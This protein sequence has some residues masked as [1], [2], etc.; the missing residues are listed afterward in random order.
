[1]KKIYIAIALFLLA[2]AV[3]VTVYSLVNGDFDIRNSASEDDENKYAPEIVSVP[4]TKATVGEKYNY[5]VKAIDNDLIELSAL[6]FIVNDKPDWLNW[7]DS[8]RMFSGTP[9]SSDVGTDTV[10][11]Q[12]S[13]GKWLGTQ[14]FSIE[15]S[16]SE[17]GDESLE[18]PGLEEEEKPSELSSEESL[19]SLEDYG[20]ETV[21]D[22]TTSSS[23]EL[24][25]GEAVLG[26]TDAELPN[27]A[28]MGVVV[29]ISLGFAVL[30]LSLYLWL[31]SK[32][33]FTDR[34]IK[35][36]E[37]ALGRQTSFQLDSG[38]TVRHRR[39]KI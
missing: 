24:S 16:K 25:G 7:S 6:N 35:R 14:T 32:Y 8:R 13:D 12:V 27:T 23:G 22:S 2:F 11:I 1:M 33:Q 26:V 37:F 21:A 19:S 38:L 29:G 10:S 9:S 5:I 4:V 31:D 34:F 20:F 36:V 18:G 17:I 39:S 15:V 28:D 30:I 3:P